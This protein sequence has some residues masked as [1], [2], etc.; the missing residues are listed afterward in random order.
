MNSRSLRFF[1]TI[2]V[3][4]AAF[5]FFWTITQF[6]DYYQPN[7]P[8]T[9]LGP[10]WWAVYIIISFLCGIIYYLW[11]SEVNISSENRAQIKIKNF[12]ENLKWAD[13]HGGGN[14]SHNQWSEANIPDIKPGVFSKY[15]ITNNGMLDTS[16]TN[17]WLELTADDGRRIRSFACRSSEGWPIDLPARKSLPVEM[18]FILLEID[19]NDVAG[20]EEVQ[21]DGEDIDGNIHSWLLK[22]SIHS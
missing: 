4:A 22:T 1:K 11:G 18:T 15:Y 5:G 14:R 17:I 19:F 6:I 7:L 16:L 2:A 13:N 3:V 9:L 20:V 21:I 10:Y 8:K 12:N